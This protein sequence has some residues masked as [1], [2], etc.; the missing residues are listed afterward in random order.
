MYGRLMAKK[1]KESYIE[2]V[3][4]YSNVDKCVIYTGVK[5]YIHKY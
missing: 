1:N 2:N 5:L 3:I 4:Q